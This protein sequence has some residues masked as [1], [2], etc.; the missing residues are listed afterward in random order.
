MGYWPDETCDSLDM[1][2]EGVIYHQNIKKD[3]ALRFLRKTVC[4]ILPI[5]FKG[6]NSMDIVN[7]MKKIYN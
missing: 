1:A 3:E 5:Q 2:T 6:K 7:P 4:R